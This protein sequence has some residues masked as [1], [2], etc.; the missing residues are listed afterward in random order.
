[1]DEIIGDSKNVK[2]SICKMRLTYLTK[3]TTKYYWRM[4]DIY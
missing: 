1:M 4:Q 3:E 2:V